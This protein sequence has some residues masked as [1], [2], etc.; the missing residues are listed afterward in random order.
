MAFLLQIDF[1][2]VLS[3]SNQVPMVL[4]LEG[5]DMNPRGA[6]CLYFSPKMKAEVTP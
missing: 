1:R 6:S 4:T 3:P 2:I 5:G